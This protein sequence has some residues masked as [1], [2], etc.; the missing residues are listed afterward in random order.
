MSIKEKLTKEEAIRRHRLM[1]NYIADESARIRTRI[2]KE[3]ALIHFGWDQNIRSKCWCCEYASRNYNTLC[4]HCPLDFAKGNANGVKYCATG[5]TDA[6][7]TRQDG[8]HTK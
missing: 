8:L 5:Y 6:N 1:W 4:D 3:D 2:G 7:G